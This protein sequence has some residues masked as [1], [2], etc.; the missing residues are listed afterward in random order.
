[1]KV[2]TGTICGTADVASSHLLPQ[3]LSSFGQ[4]D[5]HQL[6]VYL[7]ATKHKSGTESQ[8]DVEYFTFKHV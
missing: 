2:L 6:H 8:M 3:K 4:A 1:V 7:P 5:N